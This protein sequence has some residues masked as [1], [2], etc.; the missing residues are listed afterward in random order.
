MEKKRSSWIKSKAHI[1]I[2]VTLVAVAVTSYFIF[3]DFKEG[4]DEAFKVLTSDDEEYIREWV[5]HFGML[6]PLVI[7]LAM[8]VQ[9]FMFVVPNF[10]LMMIAIICYGPVWG[11]FIAL[12]GVFAS[13]SLGYFIGCKLSPHTLD[14]WV[15]LKN[16]KKIS[17]FIKRYGV[18]A[19]VITRFT[20]FSNDALSFVAGLLKMGYKKY[21]LS[22]LAGITP[23]IVTLAI[24]GRNGRIEK[25]LLWIAIA[26]LIMLVVYIR[27][28]TKRRK[29]SGN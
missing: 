13:S 17:G 6:G 11:S 19:I 25:A 1:I 24:F 2:P 27:I 28:D 18:G 8:T 14:K 3:P 26:S 12:A 20:S 15:S 23:L 10:L 5:S 9:M 21:I 22:T 29:R 7:I 4:V 16:Q